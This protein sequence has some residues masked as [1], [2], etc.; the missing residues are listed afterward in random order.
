MEQL[1]K[2]ADHAR[3]LNSY[4]G[5]DLP[6]FE[7]S[8]YYSASMPAGPSVINP[9]YYSIEE[10]RSGIRMRTGAYGEPEGYDGPDYSRTLASVYAE[11]KPDGSFTLTV[12]SMR[13]LYPE[14]LGFLQAYLQKEEG[15]QVCAFEPVSEDTRLVLTDDMLSGITAGDKGLLL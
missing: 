13:E 14:E 12:G 2:V 4:T 7:P 10:L 6:Q 9:V 1:D 15:Y 3:E 5:T 11:S 8:Y